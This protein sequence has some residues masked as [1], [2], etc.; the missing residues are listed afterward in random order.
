MTITD[1]DL[2]T[3]ARKLARTL[4]PPSRSALGFLDGD[5]VRGCNPHS[6]VATELVTEGLAVA[7]RYDVT[8]TADGRAVARVLAE[9]V[10]KTQD[11][12]VRAREILADVDPTLET[13]LVV[14]WSGCP[15][16]AP[17]GSKL[18]PYV[19][20]NG[21]INDA[22]KL[23]AAAFALAGEGYTAL[24]IDRATKI[25]RLDSL[26]RGWRRWVLWDADDMCE[27]AD[28]LRGWHLAARANNMGGDRPTC[29]DA[30]DL[31]E[32]DLET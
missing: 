21:T 1:T 13:A 2:D 7:G 29:A 20:D 31:D 23:V 26:R 25:V 14:T 15:A 18:V 5:R 11:L 17:G 3:R 12:T 27:N 32:S 28:E 16:W 19:N 24:A 8:L 30:R 10:A 6:M 9:A 22:G 4:T